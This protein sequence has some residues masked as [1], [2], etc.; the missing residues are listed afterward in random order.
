MNIRICVN[1]LQLEKKSESNSV[2]G[3]FVA[4]TF[5]CY[6][7]ESERICFHWRWFVCVCLSVT[8][9]NKEIVD[10]FAP[11]FMGMF[12]GGKVRP[13]SCFVAIGRG[14]WK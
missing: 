4:S 9:I 14:M 1:Y 10:E 7:R 13:S 2:I 6:P 11:N 3:N 8:K 12:L 5:N